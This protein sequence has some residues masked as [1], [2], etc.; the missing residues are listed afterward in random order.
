MN[1]NL[2]LR[3]RSKDEWCSGGGR[4]G[5]RETKTFR[6]LLG[7]WKRLILLR[8]WRCVGMRHP[9]PERTMLHK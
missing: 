1:L 7:M 8:I 9:V 3:R 2:H 5:M 6:A 4:A